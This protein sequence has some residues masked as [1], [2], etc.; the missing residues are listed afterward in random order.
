MYYI[1]LIGFGKNTYRKYSICSA[2]AAVHLSAGQMA[3]N[4]DNK[5]SKSSVAAVKMSLKGVP[6]DG[7]NCIKSGS[8]IIP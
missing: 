3:S 4:F 2:S 1:F 5:C 7:L 6:G 8:P